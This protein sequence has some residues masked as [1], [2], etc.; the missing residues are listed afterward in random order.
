MKGKILVCAL[1]I[2]V[3]AVIPASADYCDGIQVKESSECLDDSSIC[4]ARTNEEDTDK[5]T[6][7]MPAVSNKFSELCQNKSRLMIRRPFNKDNAKTGKLD[8]M[9]K[10]L[11]GKA[12]K[13]FGLMKD[14]GVCDEKDFT[15]GLTKHFNFKSDG[16]GDVL[17]Q[18]FLDP[19]VN[20]IGIWNCNKHAPDLD[21]MMMNVKNYQTTGNVEAMCCLKYDNGLIYGQQKIPG[22]PFAIF[23]PT[24]F[25]SNILLF[26]NDGKP[27]L[28]GLF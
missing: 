3:N 7:D 27:F 16:D 15:T 10:P 12:V 11:D 8:A 17:D 22:T 26:E 5:K 21:H 2:C 24:N 6:V 18:L 19:N 14:F 25:A 23:K 13:N 9:V 20:L 28:F 4:L 1:E